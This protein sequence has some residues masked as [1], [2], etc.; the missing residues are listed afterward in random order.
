MGKFSKTVKFMNTKTT[1][2]NILNALIHC[3]GFK[4]HKVFEDFLISMGLK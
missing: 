4:V 1:S 2:L 3:I